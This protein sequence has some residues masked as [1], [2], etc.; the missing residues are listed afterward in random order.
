MKG[1]QRVCCDVMVSIDF[2]TERHNGMDAMSSEHSC[3]S[4]SPSKSSENDI[5]ERELEWLEL[6]LYDDGGFMRY[7]P[8]N[9]PLATEEEAA[10]CEEARR[11]VE[12]QEL[13]LG[14]ARSL[15]LTEKRR[16]VHGT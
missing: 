9:E 8:E 1:G 15:G 5:S 4:S 13:E 12:E 14:S 11:E 3:T 2:W 6:E 7:N 10:A 16:S